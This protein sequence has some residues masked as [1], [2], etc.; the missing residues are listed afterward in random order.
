VATID[1]TQ[2]TRAMDIAIEKQ[3]DAMDLAVKMLIEPFG[4]AKNPERVIG[5]PLEQWSP[6]D[7]QRAQMIYGTREPN[8]LSRLIFR[9]RY[10]ALLAREKGVG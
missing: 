5:K 7:Y 8:P 1:K 3:L 6:S 10:A 2:F 4:E 9:K